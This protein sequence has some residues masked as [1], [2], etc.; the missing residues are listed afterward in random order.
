[1]KNTF[2]GLTSAIQVANTE[3]TGNTGNEN[4]NA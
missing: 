2:F 4:H 3:P 1:M